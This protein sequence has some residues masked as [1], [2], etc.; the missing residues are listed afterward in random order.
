[1]GAV[2]QGG[3]CLW[4]AGRAQGGRPSRGHLADLEAPHRLR[5]AAGIAKAARHPLVG[6]YRG[7]GIQYDIVLE[8]RAVKDHDALA[9]HDVAAHG[10]ACT[11]A[12]APTATRS[13]T[14]QG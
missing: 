7:A 13:P 10:T 4:G 8:D 2:W 6:E 12:L 14:T 1:G 11:Q 9:D 3:G 5:R